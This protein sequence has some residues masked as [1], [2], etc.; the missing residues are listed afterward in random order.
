MM[1]CLRVLQPV[2]L[3]IRCNNFTDEGIS[4]SPSLLLYSRNGLDRDGGL[5]KAKFWFVP[6]LRRSIINSMKCK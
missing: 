4:L 5:I 2:S 1:S 3:Y 6:T